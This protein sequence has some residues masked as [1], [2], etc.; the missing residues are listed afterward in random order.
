MSEIYINGVGC[1]SPQI[2]W[3]TS[4]FLTEIKHYDDN[5]MFVIEPDYSPFF[6]AG[7]MRRMSRLAKFAT[8]S[9]IITLRD[10][11]I[12]VPDAITT[13]TGFG[14][15]ENS[16]KF[17]KSVI[18]Q[19]E[20]VVSPTNFILSTHN[21][22]GGAIALMTSC[23][24]P[25]NTFSQRGSSF[26]SALMESI[27]LMKGGAYANILTGAFDELTDYSLAIMERLRL[28]RSKE[29]KST[30]TGIIVGEGAAFF[31]L[32]NNKEQNSYCRLIDTEVLFNSAT[33]DI[34]SS[35][36]S[37]LQRNGLGPHEIDIVLGGMTGDEAR[38]ESFT[39]V[40]ES[41]FSEKTIIAYKE[42]CGEYMTSSAFAMWLA[43]KIIRTGLVP[44]PLGKVGN[45]SISMKSILIHN[46]YKGT[47]TFILIGAC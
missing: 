32:S 19:K 3:D 29:D 34:K 4:T 18:E 37:F 21:T 7:S 41:L 2:T 6:D 40:N 30:Q 36:L 15:L 27:L 12:A 1:I 44:P 28:L 26:E 42:L 31:V 20:A 16:G 35:L 8:A 5:R 24:G 23:H 17:L 10:A 45:M 39:L 47:H 46:S 11:G 33:I 22:I 9:A 38:D 14:L 25:N 13:G 43:A